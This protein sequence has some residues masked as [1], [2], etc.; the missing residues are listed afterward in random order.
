MDF[1]E[2]GRFT[3]L[4]KC[5]STQCV[6]CIVL[7]ADGR[8]MVLKYRDLEVHSEVRWRFEMTFWTLIPS[9][10]RSSTLA[11]HDHDFLPTPCLLSQSVA[12]FF[13]YLYCN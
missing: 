8:D 12:P 13:P 11:R 2:T 3:T 4:F 10:F 5:R 6:H 7:G 9:D 1:S